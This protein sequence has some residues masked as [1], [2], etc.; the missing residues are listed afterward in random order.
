MKRK[1][2]LFFRIFRIHTPAYVVCFDV[3]FRFRILQEEEVVVVHS[4]FD[5]T[6]ESSVKTNLIDSVHLYR[7]L[8]LFQRCYKSANKSNEK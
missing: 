5:E 1:L 2:Q 3:K 4:A 7:M 6:V 8:C